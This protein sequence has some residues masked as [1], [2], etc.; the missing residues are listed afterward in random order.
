MTELGLRQM[1]IAAIE[2]ILIEMDYRE[3]GRSVEAYIQEDRLSKSTLF[4]R[5][6]LARVEEYGSL[7]GYM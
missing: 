7:Q 5:D 3:I 2:K 4:N 6:T 1:S